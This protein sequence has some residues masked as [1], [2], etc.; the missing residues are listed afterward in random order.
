MPWL[1]NAAAGFGEAGVA[2]HHGVMTPSLVG[3][4]AREGVP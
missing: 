3:A 1:P 2:G 4:P